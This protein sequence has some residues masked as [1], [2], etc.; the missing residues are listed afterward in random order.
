MSRKQSCMFARNASE[1][2]NQKVLASLC[3][4]EY[5]CCKCNCHES[6]AQPAAECVFLQHAV[7]TLQQQS[8]IKKVKM[9]SRRCCRGAILNLL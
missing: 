9:S 3:V 8:P 7:L 2:F 1:K 4:A 5:P 6:F